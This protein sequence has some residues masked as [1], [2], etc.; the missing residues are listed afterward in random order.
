MMS[1]ALFY[2]T[3]NWSADINST[4]INRNDITMF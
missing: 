1:C 4:T 3:S 2:N